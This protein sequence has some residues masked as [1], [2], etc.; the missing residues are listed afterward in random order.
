MSIMHPPP[1]P[2][3]TVSGALILVLTPPI[4]TS[5]D[6]LRYLLV[7]TSVLVIAP[8]VSTMIALGIPVKT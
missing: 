5:R 2:I 1:R 6:S 3:D 8:S 4:S 7:S